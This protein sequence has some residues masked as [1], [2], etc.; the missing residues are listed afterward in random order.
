MSVMETALHR[1]LPCQT[2]HGDVPHTLE[3]RVALLE[4]RL[5][6]QQL[7]HQLELCSAHDELDTFYRADGMNA[8][9]LTAA[10]PRALHSRPVRSSSATAVPIPKLTSQPQ[11]Q[12]KLARASNASATQEYMDSHQSLLNSYRQH[13]AATQRRAPRSTVTAKRALQ[14]TRFMGG[15]AAA[16]RSDYPDRTP[17][18]QDFVSHNSL[19]PTPSDLKLLPYEYHVKREIDQVSNPAVR[20]RLL[21]DFKAVSDETHAGLQR[22]LR[23]NTLLEAICERLMERLSAAEEQS[24]R[25]AARAVAAE[26]RVCKL[27]TAPGQD[28]VRGLPAR[29]GQASSPMSS[30]SQRAQ[31]SWNQH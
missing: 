31:Q 5:A 25:Y 11:N 6:E 14:P 30:P 7:V 28:H 15:R 18:S 24:A 4:K 2:S 26:Q 27:E 22:A 3:D 21:S 8:P 1:P 29:P 13:L 12:H 23:A 19:Q 16:A 9:T 20:A 17:W 10:S